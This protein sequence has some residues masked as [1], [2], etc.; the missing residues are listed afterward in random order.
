[1]TAGTVTGS[2]KRHWNLFV[3]AIARMIP[4]RIK[5]DLPSHW[6]VL[7]DTFLL[8]L[9][10]LKPLGNGIATKS[11]FDCLFVFDSAPFPRSR[12]EQRSPASIETVTWC[13]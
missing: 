13:P 3:F 12:T 5:R 8:S 9:S 6:W 4:L 10:H 7:A 1:M 11:V 2:G